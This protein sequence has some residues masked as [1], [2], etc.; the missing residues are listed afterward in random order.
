[1]HAA[2]GTL[3]RSV[4]EGSNHSLV[5]TSLV[6]EVRFRRLGIFASG[7]MLWLLSWR[8]DAM[9]NQA[10]EEPEPNDRQIVAAPSPGRARPEPAGASR[11]GDVRLGQL[12]DGLHD[13]HGR[14]PDLL[15]KGRMLPGSSPM[16]LPAGLPFATTIG[17]VIIAVL[18]PI[19]G[20]FA[21]YTARKK[22]L[23]GLFLALGVAAVAGM[24]FIHTGDWVL[25]CLLFILANIGANGSFVFYDALLPHIARDDE[26]DRVSTSGYALGYLGGGLLLALNL[27]WYLKPAWFGL[28]AGPNL[29]ESAGH[30]ADAAGVS[31]G[32][33]LVAGLLDPAVSPRA[34]SRGLSS[35]STSFADKSPI[36]AV[37]ARLAETSRELRRYRQGFLMLLAFLIYNDG[38]GTII[39]MATIYGTEMGIEQGA[40][41]KAI[42][43]VQ[44]VGIP[45][46]LSFRHAGRQDRGQAVDPA[47]ARGLHWHLHRRLLDA[48][49]SGFPDLGDPGRDGAGRYPGLK[50]LAF[51]QPDTPREVGRVFRLFRRRREVCRHLR[52]VAVRRHQHPVGIKPRSDSRGH[53]LLR[54]GRALALDGRRG[55]GPEA[56]PGRR[57][58]GTR[59]D[60]LVAQVLVSS[61]GSM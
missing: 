40:M 46:L 30:A 45:F 34:R 21:D 28:P 16:S 53:W 25:A 32:R 8:T 43:L 41:I 19:L 56:G 5:D 55:R 10:A 50:P 24:Y 59:L 42:L 39:R 51:R 47:W 48:E 3:A 12:G 60:S 57:I 44:F 2:A 14:L 1:M 17:M 23:L 27:A 61:S 29:S 35:T 15:L 38:I 36:R 37:L 22:R 52:A 7:V 9:Q 18:S 31:F 11:V 54:G 13:H 58:V 33:D 49:R 6:S 26:I 4:S 20:A